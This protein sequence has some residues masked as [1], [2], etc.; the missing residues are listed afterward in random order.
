M[1]ARLLSLLLFLALGAYAATLAAEDRRHG[2]VLAVAQRLDL[3]QSIT[4]DQIATAAAQ[5]TDPA[6]S[7]HCRSDILRPG[8][9]VMLHNLGR[10]N[11]AIDYDAWV[12]AN[13]ATQAYLGMMIRC[14][15]AD[16]NVRLREALVSRAIAEDPESL[17]Q[18]MSGARALM[19]Y[20]AQQVLARLSLW[21]RLSPLALAASE[22]LARADIAATLRHGSAA[23]KAALHDGASPAFAALVESEAG[24][25]PPS[26]G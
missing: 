17:R 10:M 5:T 15:P 9:T 24:T 3:K 14:L 19:P 21:K 11:Q 6:F 25:L 16:G 18:K 8:L 23:L 22:P 26:Q 2:Y 13:A 1:I 7:H 20:E 4:I 12:D